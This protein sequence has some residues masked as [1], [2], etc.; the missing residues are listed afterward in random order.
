MKAFAF[1]LASLFL[2]APLA[3]R[4]DLFIYKG[5][6]KVKSNVDPVD[7]T[8]ASYN[9]Y[10]LVDFGAGAFQTLDYYTKNGQKRGSWSSDFVKFADLITLFGNKP[11]IAIVS[12]DH[13]NAAT[14]F[15][16]FTEY[17]GVKAAITI[18]KKPTALVAN[19]PKT[20]ILHDT[21]VDYQ[22]SYRS[23][24]GT[25]TFNSAATLHANEAGFA[26]TDARQE[27]QDHLVDLGYA[28]P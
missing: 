21:F 24:E 22:G 19:G 2:L 14:F 18:R 25:F 26:I 20:L 6:V 23:E 5:I 9:R 12:G 4:A 13:S 10:V 3:A 17:R 11:G 1:A 8:P 15:Y 7:G 27:L 16:N 28:I